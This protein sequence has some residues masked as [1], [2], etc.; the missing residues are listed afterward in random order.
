MGN[1]SARSDL[2]NYRAGYPD[3]TDDLS[4]NDNF[5]FYNG[6]ITSQPSG[7]Y[8]DNIHTQWWGNV[9]L[10]E[11]HHGYIQWL[12]PIR[13]PGLNYQSSPIQKHEIKKIKESKQCFDRLKKSYDLMLDFY[14]SRLKN[15]E[16]GELER[17][18][19]WEGRYKNL[20][21]HSHNY[22]R[23]TRILKCLGEFELVNY[24]EQFLRH[25]IKEIW[26]NK[27]LYNCEN[28]CKNFWVGTI[29]NDDLRKQLEDEIQKYTT[30]V[31]SPIS[32]APRESNTME[33]DQDMEQSDDDDKSDADKK[34]SDTTP[35]PVETDTSQKPAETTTKSDS[36]EPMPQ[37]SNPAETVQMPQNSN[38]ADTV[39]TMVNEKDTPTIVPEGEKEIHNQV[40]PENN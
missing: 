8:I 37:N 34:N 19:K 1:T 18:E 11:A 35:K 28:S 29:R 6:D 26:V 22:L 21:T 5:L 38:P 16:T 25:Y 15:K 12:F 39:Q 4:S 3:L 23:I 32:T 13:E 17:T 9:Q 27:K 33:G 24:Q 31:E 30:K 40:V 7:D 36:T 14:G 20:N 10:L 2:E